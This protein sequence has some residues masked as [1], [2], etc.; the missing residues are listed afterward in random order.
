MKQNKGQS[1]TVDPAPQ[2]YY[3]E[4]GAIK[5]DRMGGKGSENDR[6]EKKGKTVGRPEPY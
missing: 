1:L 2:P 6:T 4:V 3:K 5:N